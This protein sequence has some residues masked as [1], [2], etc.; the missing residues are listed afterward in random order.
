MRRSALARLAAAAGNHE[1][2]GAREGHARC[3]ALRFGARF[4]AA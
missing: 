3:S 4:A 1:V 2:D